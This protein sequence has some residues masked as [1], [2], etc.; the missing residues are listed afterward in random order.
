MAKITSFIIAEANRAKGGT[1]V[2]PSIPAKS[3]PHYFSQSVPSQFILTKDTA[4]VLARE[5]A[6]AVKAYHPDAIVIEA[7]VEVADLFAED[8]LA[9][10]DALHEKCYALAETHGAKSG[11]FEEYT[12]Y[13]VSEYA[14]DPEK[15]ITKRAQEIAGLLKSERTALSQEEIEHTFSSKFKYE[16]DDLIIV[17][18]DG[19]IV[20]NKNTDNADI[21]EL[22]ELANYQLLRYRMLDSDLDKKTARAGELV[23]YEE[24]LKRKNW[25]GLPSKKITDEFK[26]IIRVRSQSIAKFEGLDRD[27]KLIGDWY[28]A[29][30]YELVAKKL[31]L[32]EWRRSVKEKLESIEDIYTIAGENL[33]MSRMQRLELVQIGAFFILQVGWFIILILEF[34]YFTR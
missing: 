28:M 4:S 19:A 15:I 13:H 18:W 20:F 2:V 1:P 32:E 17:D 9:I 34:I 16:K 30:L 22:L 12:V 24:Q 25:I 11:I 10:K 7:S 27:I 29:R 3:A 14:G 26:E 6:I 23:R 31:R 21:I 8:I 5:A 33:G